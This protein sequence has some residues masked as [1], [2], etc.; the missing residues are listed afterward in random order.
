[1]KSWKQTIVWLLLAGAVA[2]LAA[3]EEGVFEDAGEEVDDAVDDA[4]DEV[5]RRN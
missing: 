3:C 5:D 1:M 2:P 4:T